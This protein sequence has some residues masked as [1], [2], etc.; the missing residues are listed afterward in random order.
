MKLDETIYRDFGYI[1]FTDGR[2]LTLKSKKSKDKIVALSQFPHDLTQRLG[3]FI[4][5]NTA[6]IVSNTRFGELEQIVEETIKNTK[7][8]KFPFADELLVRTSTFTQKNEFSMP[9][10]QVPIG[11]NKSTAEQIIKIIK[12]VNADQILL[13]ERESLEKLKSHMIAIRVKRNNDKLEAEIGQGGIRDI[14]QLHEADKIAS[15]VFGDDFSFD[16]LKGTIES[17]DIQ[18]YKKLLFCI[19]L[20]IPYIDKFMIEERYENS[21]I[22]YEFRV[23]PHQNN[24]YAIFNDIEI[25]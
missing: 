23:S 11:T 18:K 9:N 12:D 22:V 24:L 6:T 4:C 15:A 21:D 20:F 3:I 1:E 5:T 10:P 19:K 25:A 7:R 16:I 2:G 13:H 8:I 17:Q 14:Y